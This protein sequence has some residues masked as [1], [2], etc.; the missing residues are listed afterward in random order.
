[1]IATARTLSALPWA[2]ELTG[3]IGV[4]K[5]AA[6]LAAGGGVV[7]YDPHRRGRPRPMWCSP[8]R[9][10]A[11]ESMVFLLSQVCGHT[12][13]ASDA[14][15]WTVSRSPRC[16]VR[17][18][19]TAPPTTSRST[20]LATPGPGSGPAARAATMHLAHPDATP[21]RLPPARACVPLAGHRGG[22]SVR[23][24]AHRGVAGTLRG[25]WTADGGRHL[26]GDGPRRSHAQ[27]SGGRTLRFGLVPSA[28]LRRR[29][30]TALIDHEDNAYPTHTYDVIGTS[31]NATR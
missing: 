30:G 9:P 2:G 3:P 11:P 13:V 27:R 25:C 12:T 20:S 24:G 26:R 31:Y 6:Q 21:R 1:M 14:T 5:C 22:L 28:Y 10:C 19:A 7:I 18:T 8:G 17:E 16:P 15:G 23:V 4:E 29:T